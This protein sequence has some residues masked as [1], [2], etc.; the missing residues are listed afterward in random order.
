MQII[1]ILITVI[2]PNNAIDNPVYDVR[3]FYVCPQLPQSDRF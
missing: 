2:N 1:F 3:V